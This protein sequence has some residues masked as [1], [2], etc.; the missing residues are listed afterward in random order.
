MGDFTSVAGEVP[1]R[2]RALKAPA[3]PSSR[4]SS[5]AEL[6]ALPRALAL[7]QRRARGSPEATTGP[8]RASSPSSGDARAR[9]P[10]AKNRNGSSSSAGTAARRRR[11]LQQRRLGGD[12]GDG[13][14]D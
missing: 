9:P 7:Q 3:V 11:L 12:C 5:N 1:N 10:E 6:A 8:C 2:R 13:D 4:P 14:G